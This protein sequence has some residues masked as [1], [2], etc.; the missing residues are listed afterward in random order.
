MLLQRVKVLF[1]LNFKPFSQKRPL[2]SV[3]V[4]VVLM[5]CV[6][7][8]MV[9]VVMVV[10]VA[11]AVAGVVVV[12]YVVMVVVVVRVVV[13][14]CTSNSLGATSLW[15]AGLPKAMKYTLCKSCRRYSH[16]GPTKIYNFWWCPKLKI[17]YI[18]YSLNKS[19]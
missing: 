7:V 10:V 18:I 15:P 9:V 17:K 12:V 4:A 13:L 14:E 6:F 16:L 2:W 19:I 8:V 11:V 5:D 1:D 3:V